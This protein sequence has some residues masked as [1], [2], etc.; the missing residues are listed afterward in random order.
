MN[1]SCYELEDALVS[2]CACKTNA[3]LSHKTAQP[4]L[5]WEESRSHLLDARASF[6]EAPNLGRCD[7]RVVW[8]FC[9]DS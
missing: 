3:K 9:W 2:P 8:L 5:P 7:L 4:R 1:F 6:Q